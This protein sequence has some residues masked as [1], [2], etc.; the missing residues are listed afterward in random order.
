MSSSG[1]TIFLVPGQVFW[2]SL[3][4]CR[5]FTGFNLLFVSPAL[6]LAHFVNVG[7]WCVSRLVGFRDRKGFDRQ[8]FVFSYSLLNAVILIQ[9]AVPYM[10]CSCLYDT[11]KQMEKKSLLIQC[12]ILNRSCLPF[13]S[14]CKLKQTDNRVDVLSLFRCKFHPNLHHEKKIDITPKTYNNYAS[15]L[16]ELLRLEHVLAE[17]SWMAFCTHHSWKTTPVFSWTLGANAHSDLVI[18]WSWAGVSRQVFNETMNSGPVTHLP[19]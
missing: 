7:V 2:I 18:K 1:F 10:Y 12:C 14:D 3:W 15:N 8:C 6:V 11:G 5:W 4:C 9:V 19:I 13:D 16:W 17:F